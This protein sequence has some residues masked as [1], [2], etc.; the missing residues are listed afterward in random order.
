M[1]HLTII[2][3]FALVAWAQT[4]KPGVIVGGNASGGG[5]GS[6]TAGTGL[7]LIGDQFSIN[8]AV[9]AR[10]LDM[11]SGAPNYCASTT[12]N[13]TYTCTLTPTLT[14]YTTGQCLVLYPDTANTTTATVNVDTLGAK[15]I[16]NRGA[17]A[18]STGD[19][20]ASEPNQICYDGTQFILQG[21]A[22]GGSTT[23]LSTYQFNM[24]MT[25]STGTAQF[26]DHFASLGTYGGTTYIAP[27]FSLTSN[28]A[29]AY[30]IFP[31]AVSGT[32]YTGGLFYWILP[33]TWRSTSDTKV[34]VIVTT[35]SPGGDKTIQVATSCA[36]DGDN[37]N[38]TPTFNAD[39]TVVIAASSVGPQYSGE[40]TLDM[41]GCVAGDTFFMKVARS[42][43]G[44]TGNAWIR[45]L[46]LVMTENLN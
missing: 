31:P 8:T 42:D 38:N 28:P 40:I 27:T 37:V 2:L 16:L 15:S 33:S 34:K 29:K 22:A 39:Q 5:D 19:I 1:R 20:K 32:N 24:A 17:A 30:A 3:A 11:Q 13:D 10:K 4:P 6:Y 41:T 14:T 35:A 43:T 26:A 18:L 21:A 23:R 9:T 25:N 7:S 36:S 46:Q 45:G 44:A 12:G